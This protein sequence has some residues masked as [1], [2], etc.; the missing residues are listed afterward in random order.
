[1][2]SA[3]N[4]PAEGVLYLGAPLGL[5]GSLPLWLFLPIVLTGF[6]LG[7]WM[8]LELLY[9]LVPL[10]LFLGTW[11]LIRHTKIPDEH[12]SWEYLVPI[13]ASAL[14]FFPLFIQEFAVLMEGQLAQTA[15]MSGAS[16]EF[17]SSDSLLGAVTSQYTA[18]AGFLFIVFLAIA[19]MNLTKLGAI[20]SIISF[21]ICGVVIFG[22]GGGLINTVVMSNSASSSLFSYANWVYYA[23]L[24]GIPISIGLIEHYWEPLEF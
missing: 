16:A 13:I 10:I 7:L 20:G 17:S 2:L 5:L 4:N 19:V 1:M 22:L 8:V 6:G 21:V 11:W 18:I 3:V 9:I 15:G 24:F 23:I 12:P 14:A